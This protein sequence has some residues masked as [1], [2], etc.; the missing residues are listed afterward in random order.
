MTP[1]CGNEAYAGRQ[2]NTGPYACLCIRRVRNKTLSR[3]GFISAIIMSLLNLLT[4]PFSVCLHTV[5]VS[6]S[7]GQDQTWGQ[8]ERSASK[9]AHSA[10]WE[11]ELERKKNKLISEQAFVVCLFW[12]NSTATNTLHFVLSRSSAGLTIKRFTIDALWINGFSQDVVF[13][14]N[15][16]LEAAIQDN[17]NYNF[18]YKHYCCFC[19]T[20]IYL[21]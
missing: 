9:T 15:L 11:W 21:F 10:L 1:S 12:P 14:L 20:L 19:T 16:S 18:N 4:L 3:E 6:A 7:S 17:F 5:C 8:N 2:K 13:C